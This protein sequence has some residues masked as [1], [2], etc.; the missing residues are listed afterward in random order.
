M[1]PNRFRPL[2]MQIMTYDHIQEYDSAAQLAQE[3]LVKSVKIP[4]VEIQQ[5]QSEAQKY[6][7]NLN[8]D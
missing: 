8:R 1:C 3:L 5:M 7:R 2:Y 6:I 4:S